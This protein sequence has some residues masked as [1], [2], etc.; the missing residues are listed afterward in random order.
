MK[1]QYDRSF[2][3]KIRDDSWECYIVTDEEAAEL[4]EKSEGFRGL[5]IT[6]EKCIFI[7]EEHLDKATIMHELFHLHVEYLHL[8][9]ADLSVDTFEEI[10]AVLLENEID[11]LVKLRDRLY[12]KFTKINSPKKSEKKA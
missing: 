7:N 12:N 8:S 4:W 5:T 3:F 11:K 9:S 10:I 2:K 1:Y 6:E